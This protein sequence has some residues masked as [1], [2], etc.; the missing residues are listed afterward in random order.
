MKA[1]IGR[2]G[3]LDCLHSKKKYFQLK[4]Y[5]DKENARRDSNQRLLDYEMCLSITTPHAGF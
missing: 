3:M 4:S 1:F 2:L 5:T